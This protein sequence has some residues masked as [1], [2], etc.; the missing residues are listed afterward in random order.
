MDLSG[1]A[2]EDGDDGAGG[3]LRPSAD[4]RAAL[5]T[6]FRWYRKTRPNFAPLFVVTTDVSGGM[7]M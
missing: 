5:N 1:A 3:A 6:R 2:S 4:M 7:R